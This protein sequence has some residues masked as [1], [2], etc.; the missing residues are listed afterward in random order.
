MWNDD[1]GFCRFESGAAIYKRSFQHLLSGFPGASF[2]EEALEWLE[3]QAWP[4]NVR[5]LR[6]VVRRLV[7][8]HDRDH[9]SSHPAGVRGFPG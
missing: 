8:L 6:D 9:E 1:F 3:A 5:Q 7:L 4:E 2:D